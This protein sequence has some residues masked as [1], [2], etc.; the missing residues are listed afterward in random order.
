MNRDEYRFFRGVESYLLRILWLASGRRSP[1][2]TVI[3]PR[4]PGAEPAPVSE[5]DQRVPARRLTVPRRALEIILAA[6]GRTLMLGTL[7]G[8]ILAFGM[9]SLGPSDWFDDVRVPLWTAGVVMSCVTVFLAIRRA[10]NERR[11]DE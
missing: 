7:L 5:R 6:I 11:R 4:V 10:V 8:L 3:L 1:R 9:L 2:V